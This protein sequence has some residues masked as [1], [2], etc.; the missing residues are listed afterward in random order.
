MLLKIGIVGHGKWKGNWLNNGHISLNSFFYKR[1]WDF[2]EVGV[3]LPYRVGLYLEDEVQ[4]QESVHAS[5]RRNFRPIRV[6]AG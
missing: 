1:I 6:I 2:E 3:D 5:K 4:G